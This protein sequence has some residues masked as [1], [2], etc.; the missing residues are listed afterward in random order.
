MTK[1]IIKIGKVKKTSSY[2]IPYYV[3][4]NRLV[5]NTYKWKPKRNFYN[6]V[7]DTYVWL[8]NNKKS[9]KKYF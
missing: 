3:T 9:I 1:N 5:I 4:D 2:D 6:I 7:K 8:S